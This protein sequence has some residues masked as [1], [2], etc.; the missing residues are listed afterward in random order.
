MA[1][2]DYDRG[3]DHE[4]VDS[5]NGDEGLLALVR[6]ARPHLVRTG[7]DTEPWLDRLEEHHDGLHDLMERLLAADPQT[8]AELAATLWPFW[9]QRGHMTEGR[10]LLERAVTIEG[11]DRTR[12][13]RGLGTIAFRQGDVEAA[14]RAFL[15]RLE[16]VEHDGTQQELAEAFA[17]LARIAL[18]RGDFAEV[19][20]YAERGHAAAEG[21]GPEAIRGPIHMRAAAA[22]MEGRLDEARALYL[23]SRELGES[24]GNEVGVAGEDHN[25]LYVALHSGDR[26]EAGRRF[27]MS[28]EWIFANDNAYLRPYAFL[29]AGI[30]ALH[31]GDLERAGRLVASAQRIFEDTDSIPDPDDRVELDDAIVR[32]KDQLGDRFDAVWF[33]GRSLSLDEAQTLARA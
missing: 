26:E 5:V 9:W 23:E 33:D 17:D 30:L 11:A 15:E 31:D 28:S 16:L 21:L 27:R 32:L 2:A 12:A 7:A 8:A 1:E 4:P 19:R 24:L 13:L 10:E 25:L 18:R 29:D 20:R 3:M 14:E 6:E 22:R